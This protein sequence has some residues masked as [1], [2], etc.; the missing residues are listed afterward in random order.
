MQRV[1][2]SPG[3]ALVMLNIADPASLSEIAMVPELISLPEFW[4][5]A[6]KS[7]KTPSATTLPSAPTTTAEARI[8][9]DLFICL[10]SLIV[11]LLWVRVKTGC[12]RLLAAG[13]PGE[14]MDA[15]AP[16]LAAVGGAC[17]EGGLEA[18]DEG[19]AGAP[20]RFAG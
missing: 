19:F 14:G 18:I 4:V 7:P 6:L 13:L 11:L 20:A 9:C 16:A 8:F 15:G 1:Q 5:V 12:R 17:L 2:L 10:F 3:L